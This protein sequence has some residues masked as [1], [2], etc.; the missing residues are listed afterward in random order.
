MRKASHAFQSVYISEFLA[1]KAALRKPSGE[2]VASTR[3]ATPS[4]RRAS[5][6]P[7]PTARKTSLPRPVD[8]ALPPPNSLFSSPL[9]NIAA[10][11]S[12]RLG[13]GAAKRR[14]RE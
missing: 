14:A 10:T 12:Q 13:Y 7:S 2:F 6:T 4:P 9:G 1:Q 8:G 3:E 5:A 11:V